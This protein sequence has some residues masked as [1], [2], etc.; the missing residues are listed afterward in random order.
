MD[1]H[2]ERVRSLIAAEPTPLHDLDGIRGLMLRLC[3]AMGRVVGASGVGL[4]VMAK[5]GVRGVIVA[6]DP[7][8]ERLEELQY[9]LGEGPCV[10]A[11]GRQHPVLVPSLADGA[12]TRWP[13]Y[14]PAAYDAGIRAVFAFPLQVGGARLGIMDVFRSHPGAL[15]G[16]EFRLALTFADAAV[17]TLLDSQAQVPASDDLD[18]RL[19]DPLGSR[20]ELF[21]AQGMV[22]A[23]LGTN[24]HDA[25]ARMRAYAYAENR[26]LA[27]VATDVVARRLRFDPDPS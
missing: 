10:D 14:A 11:F 19:G 6:T 3:A 15:S 5:D 18:D 26:H 25:M 24:L 4:T 9:T 21:Q 17:S 2:M 12:M 16:E 8:T 20:T 13:T 7:A 23:Q 27:D 22:M 1:D